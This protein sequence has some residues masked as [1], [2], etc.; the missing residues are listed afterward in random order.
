MLG[1]NMVRPDLVVVSELDVKIARPHQS[2]SWIVSTEEANADMDIKIKLQI[3]LHM[4]GL[5][6]DGFRSSVWQQCVIAAYLQVTN[7]IQ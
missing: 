1:R 4:C 5:Q 3:N 7:P 2:V 6:N